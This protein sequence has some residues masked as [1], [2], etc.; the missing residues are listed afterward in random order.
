MPRPLP[1]TTTFRLDVVPA[2]L[3]VT[4]NNDHA[5]ILGNDNASETVSIVD[6]PSESGQPAPL[7]WAHPYPQMTTYTYQAPD[8]D[9]IQVIISGPMRFDENA[10]VAG[11]HEELMGLTVPVG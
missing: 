7:G 8:D 10:F 2:G 6:H 9:Y 1:V 3:Q 5:L 4:A 11:I